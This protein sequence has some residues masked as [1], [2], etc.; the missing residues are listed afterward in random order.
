M[1]CVENETSTTWI[2]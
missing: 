1:Q 2:M